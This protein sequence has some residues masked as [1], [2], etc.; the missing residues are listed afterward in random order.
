MAV[1]L[2]VHDAAGCVS[3]FC[4]RVRTAVRA[5]AEALAAQ[6]GPKARAIADKAVT[7]AK[8][9]P[10]ATAAAALR[11]AAA[12]IGILATMRKKKAV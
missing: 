8:E 2:T 10:I 1:E 3:G 12:L 5:A 11:A 9:H 6:A 7:E 4:A